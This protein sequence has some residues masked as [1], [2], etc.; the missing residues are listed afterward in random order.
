[1]AEQVLKNLSGE[2]GC[3]RGESRFQAVRMPLGSNSHAKQQQGVW[4]TVRD[5]A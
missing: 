3:W 1:M 5:I 2:V 4:P